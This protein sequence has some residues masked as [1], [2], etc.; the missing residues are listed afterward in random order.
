MTTDVFLY[1][2]V[3]T[4]FGRYGG[5]LANTRPDDLA[6]HVV[7]TL[8]ERSPALDPGRVDEIV[9]G[10]ANG[11]GEDNRNVARMA[12]LLAGLP[13]EVPATTVNRLCGS[14]LDAA[15]IASRQIAL[16]EADLMVVGGVES[17]SR[18]PWVLPKSQRPFPPGDAT[19]V[20]TTLGWRLVNPAMP[21]EWTVSLGEATEL[22]RE[23]EGIER[24]EQDA[25]AL[26]SHQRAAAAWDA[27]FYDGLTVAV[28]GADLARDE[29]IRADTSLAQL[30]GL[31]PS[32]RPDGTVTAGNASPLNDGASAALL[33]NAAAADLLGT[34]PV[35]RIAARAASAL[36]PRYFGF[37]PVEA[38][39]KAL[40]RAGIGWSDVG[41][42]E[43]NEAFAAQS[44][45]CIKAWGIDPAIV[46]VHGGA[47]A[48]GH[49][50]GASGTRILGTLARIL[51]DTGERWGVATICIGVGQGLAVVLENAGA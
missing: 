26:A 5:A 31:K 51:Q 47:I 8:V 13:V 9:L 50:L 28:P 45:A 40:A 33:G 12:G 36:D 14:S 4:P 48:I 2:A 41:A 44:L 3:R 46:N 6:A 43:L 27:G 7:R 35:A 24:D 39:E 22:L 11:A 18:A 17:M 15:I 34:A 42:V 29:S 23:R 10:N 19:L 32:F 49:P 30:A 37:A 1:D 16:G 25:F 21:A 20:S 38:T